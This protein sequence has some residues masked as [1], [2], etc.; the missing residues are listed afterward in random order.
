MYQV[1]KEKNVEQVIGKIRENIGYEWKSFNEDE[2][3]LLERLLAEVWAK[4]E[5]KRWDKI[6]FAHMTKEDVRKILAAGK[7]MDLDKTPPRTI[8]E[9]VEKILYALA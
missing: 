3:H 9:N 2:V 5:Q 1:H 4:T 6:P 7:H 8:A